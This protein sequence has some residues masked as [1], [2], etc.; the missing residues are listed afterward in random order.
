MSDVPPAPKDTPPQILTYSTAPAHPSGPRILLRTFLILLG[1]AIGVVATA[2]LG[3]FVWGL[4]GYDLR[5]SPST[6]PIWPSVLFGAF[7]VAGIAACIFAFRRFRRTAKWLL[8][9]LLIAAGFAS[10]GEGFCF[11]NQ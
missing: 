11:L 8:L 2:A 6:R 7:F 4:A 9:G 3:V 5:H 1:V 10:L